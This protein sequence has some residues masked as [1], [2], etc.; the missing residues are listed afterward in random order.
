MDGVGVEIIGD[1]ARV[2]V[3]D[4]ALTGEVAA[5]LLAVAE[6]PR[7][8]RTV[9][10]R[11]RPGFVAPVAVVEAAGLIHHPVEPVEPVE[12]VAKRRGRPPKNPATE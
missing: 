9:T 10:D 5:L 1:T 7:D 3:L 4:H 6:D 11:G 8:V 2:G 12:P